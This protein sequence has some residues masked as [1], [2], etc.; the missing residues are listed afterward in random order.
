MIRERVIVALAVLL[1]IV[2]FGLIFLLAGRG[3]GPSPVPWESDVPAGGSV[4]YHVDVGLGVCSGL[5]G[6]PTRIV[7]IAGTCI[8]ETWRDDHWEFRESKPC[9][10]D[11][12]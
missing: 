7:E 10:V 11:P 5:R 9:T 3:S 1:L 6:C 12:S 8:T 4:I 2:V